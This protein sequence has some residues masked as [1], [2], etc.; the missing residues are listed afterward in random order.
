MKPPLADVIKQ[1]FTFRDGDVENA[2]QENAAPKC[3]GG[4]CRTGK[5][6]TRK[7]ME[8]CKCINIALRI[9]LIDS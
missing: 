8:H 9:H 5:F 3:M 4:K 6:G 1:F 2:G 7:S